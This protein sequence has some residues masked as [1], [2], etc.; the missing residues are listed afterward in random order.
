MKRIIFSVYLFGGRSC[1]GADRQDNEN[2]KKQYILAEK[3]FAKRD[4]VLEGQ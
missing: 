4:I 2:K 1:M 3:G